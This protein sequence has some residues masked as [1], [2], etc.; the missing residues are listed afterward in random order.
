VQIVNVFTLTHSFSKIFRMVII[1]PLPLGKVG[2]LLLEGQFVTG[3]GCVCCPQSV[4]TK[5]TELMRAGNG[6]AFTKDLM[7]KCTQIGFFWQF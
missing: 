1:K 7:M 3:P 2:S 4:I 5:C 6:L